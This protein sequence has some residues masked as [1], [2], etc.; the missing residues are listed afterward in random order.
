MIQSFLEKQTY[1][2]LFFLN[3]E[4]QKPIEYQESINKKAI[5]HAKCFINSYYNDKIDSIF[6]KNDSIYEQSKGV[7]FPSF[8][9]TSNYVVRLN[10][11][12]Y[13]EQINHDIIYHK[14]AANE[15]LKNSIFKFN[16]PSQMGPSAKSSS[17]LYYAGYLKFVLTQGQELKIYLEKNTGYKRDY[18]VSVVI[19]SSNSCFNDLMYPHSLQTIVTFLRTLSTI[20]IPYFDL[21]VATS[22]NPLILAVN[23][24]SQN[25]LDP[26]GSYIWPSLFSILEKKNKKS[27]LN[28]AVLSAMQLKS[29]II[30]KKSFLFVFTDGL[31]DSNEVN[32]LKNLFLSCREYQITAIGIAIGL[33]PKRIEKIF[34]QCVWS[35]NPTYII[36]AIST[37]FGNESSNFIDEIKLFGPPPPE[38]DEIKSLMSSICENYPGT[39]LFKDLYKHLYN[40]ALCKESFPAYQSEIKNISSLKINPS[41]TPKN[42]MYL[43]NTFKGQKILI[44]AYWSKKIAGADEYEWVDPI[45]LKTPFQ[46]DNPDCKCVKDVLSYYGIEIDIVMNYKEAIMKLQSGE[47]FQ[48]WVICGD[49][50]INLP[51]ENATKN[52][53]AYLVDQFI[54]CLEIYWKSGGGV[55]FWCDNDPLFFQA[56]LFLERV[57]FPEEVRKTKVRIVE[58]YLGMKYIEIGK[59][60]TDNKGVFISQNEMNMGKYT[61]SS[62]SHNLVKLYEGYTISRANYSDIN[63]IEPFLP[64]V[65]DS[66]GGLISFYY[67]SKPNNQCGDLFF[68]CGFTKLFYELKYSENDGTERYILNIAGFLAQYERRHYELGENGPKIF[69]PTKFSMII[70]ENKLSSSIL[71]PAFDILYLVDATGS[72]SGQIQSAKEECINISNELKQELPGFDFQFGAIFYRDPIDSP[73]DQSYDDKETFQ[74]TT[75]LI[76]LK[77]KIGTVRATGGGDGPEDWVGAYK[78]ALNINWR[79]GTRLIIHI[80]DAPAH[81]HSYADSDRHDE[82]NP[83]LAPLLRKCASSGI[84]IVGMCIGTYPK[85]S[86]EQCKKDYYEAEHHEK[87]FYQ[88]QNFKESTNLSQHFKDAIVHATV[89]AAPKTIK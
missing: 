38:Y 42:I 19:D 73:S 63:N 29:T 77:N 49:N 75:D 80:A 21:I 58:G 39:I 50:S 86:F 53:E 68:D 54:D 60:S 47:Y 23:Q 88:I 56:N 4:F 1:P 70:D 10:N 33:Y 45:Y 20:Q 17:R 31:Y 64:F 8:R 84:K 62:I 51:D 76:D 2:Y 41:L 9:I 89:C 69:R 82:E 34:Q 14:K 25:C 55:C 16:K 32:S 74:L 78:R 30:A 81:G 7:L 18:R 13:D 37:F 27:N 46:K 44:C 15:H 3:H 66:E 59:M 57:E 6:V 11:A 43:K 85:K 12:D 83:K 28:D 71:N 79:K 40:Q 24:N 67:P 72:M 36:T 87:M 26:R 61:R 65:Y 52:N 35:I 22:E 5:D 48:A